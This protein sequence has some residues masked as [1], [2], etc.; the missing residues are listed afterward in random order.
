MI[1]DVPLKELLPSNSGP[2]FNEIVP[3][4]VPTYI[5]FFRKCRDF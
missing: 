2:K 5:L 1:M 3:L 4:V